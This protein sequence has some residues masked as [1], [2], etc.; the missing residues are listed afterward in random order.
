[1]MRWTVRLEART[2]QGGVT[3][4]ELVTFD[5]PVVNGT[6]ADLGLAL[7][8]A[9]A[10]LAELQASMVQSQVVEYAGH[11]RVCPQCWV[12]QALKD[13]RTRRL[14]SLFGTVE[15]E[16]PRFRVC[17]CRLPR[18]AAAG[19]FS[20]VCALLTA[21]RTPELERVQAELGAR[22]SF[23]EAARILEAL[24]PT[25]PANHESV[26]N[27]THAVALR[28]EAADRRAAAEG[29]AARDR[30]G[31]AGGGRREPAHRHARR[32]LRARAVPGHRARSFEAVCGEV[33]QEG[34]SSRRFA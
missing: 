28:L 19:T 8:E 9:K 14:Q 11:R 21:R 7:S 32:R 17:R 24:L 26:R 16:A 2:D 34:R 33:E 3:T 4:T 13:R 23:R 10:V 15:V 27:R 6:L 20:P 29:V 30:P 25:S 5:R 18:P 12:P 22:T 31:K 1:M